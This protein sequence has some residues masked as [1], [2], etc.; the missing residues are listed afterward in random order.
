LGS[1]GDA[2]SCGDS[3]G[4]SASD[5]H[6]D[7]YIGYLLV[8]S[9]EDVV[10]LEGELGLIDETDAFRGPSERGNHAYPVYM[11]GRKAGIR[12]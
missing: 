10:L 6:G 7:D 2:V 8:G 12:D 3:D 5:D 9:G 11:L 1:E 4:W